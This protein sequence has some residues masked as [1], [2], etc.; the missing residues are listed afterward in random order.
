MKSGPGG[1]VSSLN[2]Q[3]RKDVPLRKELDLF[4]KGAQEVGSI[5]NN[6]SIRLDVFSRPL[7]K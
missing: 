2:V 7:I 3:L 5:Y 6:G 4:A 1:G